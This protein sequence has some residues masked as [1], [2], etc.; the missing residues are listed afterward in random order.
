MADMKSARVVFD[1]F[2]GGD[3][4]RDWAGSDSDNKFRAINIIYYPGGWI[5]PRQPL[6]RFELPSL[7][8]ERALPDAALWFVENDLLLMS[9][10]SAWNV[11]TGESN[12]PGDDQPDVTLFRDFSVSHKQN[13]EMFCVSSDVAVQPSTVIGVKNGSLTDTHPVFFDR[14]VGG[15]TPMPDGLRLGNLEDTDVL[16]S[17]RVFYWAENNQAVVWD[18]VNFNV[19]GRVIYD[20]IDQKNTLVLLVGARDANTVSESLDAETRFGFVPGV[21]VFVIY[22]TLGADATFRRVDTGPAP[23]ATDTGSFIWSVSGDDVLWFNNRWLM[24]FDGSEVTVQD[25]PLPRLLSAAGWN[26]GP[27]AVVNFWCQNPGRAQGEYLLSGSL[28]NNVGEADPNLR[29]GVFNWFHGKDAKAW[30]SHDPGIEFH[31]EPAMDDAGFRDGSALS[32]KGDGNF[33]V[34]RR[35]ENAMVFVTQGSTDEAEAPRFYEMDLRSAFPSVAANDGD[36]DAPVT[37]DF[38]TA[39]YW[40]PEGREMDVEGIWLDYAYEPQT[41]TELQA[42]TQTITLEIESVQLDNDARFRPG[43]TVT[44][45]PTFTPAGVSSEPGT[46]IV[47]GRVFIPVRS[48]GTGNGFRI[49]ATNWRGL[50]VRRLTADVRFTGAR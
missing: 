34:Y 4:G 13:G 40:D 5:G 47:R 38:Y 19:T 45:T 42:A 44:F 3:Y 20:L 30:T 6:V 27:D 11:Q 39:D 32:R 12:D 26:Y 23:E 7:E 24:K 28:A 50:A 2:S 35:G 36:T 37:A 46:N 16:A 41:T 33:Y 49:H 1:D 48:S 8:G 9:D 25:A 10:G 18:P 21:Q 22:G 15:P 29:R 17:W 14:P 43:G 31:A